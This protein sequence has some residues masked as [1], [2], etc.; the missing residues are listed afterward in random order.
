MKL[1]AITIAYGAVLL[2][3]WKLQEV[4]QLLG[5]TLGVFGI[6][7]TTLLLVDYLARKT[8]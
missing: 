6:L 1:T 8:S 2:T 3:S 5:Y 4:D 7:A